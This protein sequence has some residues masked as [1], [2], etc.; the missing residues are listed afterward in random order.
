MSSVTSWTFFCFPE[1]PN[2]SLSSLSLATQAVIDC[3]TGWQEF[4]DATSLLI[5]F[6]MQINRCSLLCLRPLPPPP[7]PGWRSSCCNVACWVFLTLGLE[8][9]TE[10]I[11][12]A[13][14]ISRCS[15]TRATYKLKSGAV[16]RLLLI[17]FCS[18]SAPSVPQCIKIH[19]S[20]IQLLT[21]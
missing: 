15:K 12:D 20:A 17:Y 14:W 8:T 18:N 5:N 6:V 10:C 7:P 19:T 1:C 16:T 4:L 21:F 9:S 11:T 3:V 13:T 2:S